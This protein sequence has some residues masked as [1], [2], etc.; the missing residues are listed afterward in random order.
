MVV[1]CAQCKG[2]ASLPLTA[3]EKAMEKAN[4]QYTPV[5]QALTQYWGEQPGTSGPVYVGAFILMLFV[6]SL[7]VVKGPMKWCLLV[8]TV[9][10]V[11]LSWGR[12]F[13]GLT[14]FFLDYVPM[15]DKFRA[16]A[17]ILVVAEFTIPLLAMLGLK[18]V[19]EQP[20]V[21]KAK[22]KY[23]YISFALTGGFALLFAL[24]PDAFSETIFRCPRWRCYRM[25]QEKAIF[26]RICWAVSSVICMIC[27]RRWLWPIPGAVSS[28]WR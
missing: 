3:S 28:S 4:P 25:R 11:M 13:M 1:A 10:S 15:Y 26:H 16:V 27:V 5:Y 7:F 9:F 24:M 21:L 14:D 12:N 8:L 23:V 6:L 2:R 20:E 17:S 22:L 18:T 19:L